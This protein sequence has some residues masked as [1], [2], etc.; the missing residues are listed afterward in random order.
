M[1][2]RDVR[3]RLEEPPAVITVLDVDAAVVDD[4]ALWASPRLRGV[5][6]H[7]RTI[8]SP[9]EGFPRETMLEHWNRSYDSLV[10]KADA[11]VA[12]A[13]SSSPQVLAFHPSYYSARRSE[14]YSTLA[15]PIA[16]K[17]DFK[18]D[19]VVLLIDDIY[20]VQ[21]R[22]GSS[23]DIYDLQK[24]LD[25]HLLSQKLDNFRL[26]FGKGTPEEEATW[27]R[28]RA[29]NLNATLADIAVWRRF[30]MVQAELLAQAHE[31]RVTVLGVKHPFRSLQQLLSD[32]LGTTTT[33]LS[34]PI[35]RPRRAV[36]SGTV[37]GWP[38]VVVS[39]NRL[40]DR[41][42]AEN[43]ELVM[44]TSIDEFRVVPAK[45]TPFEREYRLGPRWPDLS[46]TGAIL[47]NKEPANLALT[48]SGQ[49]VEALGTYA[50]ALE[51]MIIGE[52][53]F[54]DHYLV[55]NTDSF[56]VYR[57]LFGVEG[58]ISSSE[59]GGSFSGGV[60]AEIDHWVDSWD[61]E[62]RKR[63]RRA[64]F[65][66]CYSDV[67]EIVW[68][69]AGL[70]P[71]D[72]EA[73]ALNAH[74]LEQSLRH[75]LR[76]QFGLKHADVEAVLSG[77]ELRDD[78]LDSAIVDAS[79]DPSAILSQA[80]E[81][82]G[83]NYFVQYLTGGIERAEVLESGDVAIYLTEN[84]ELTDEELHACAEYL[85]GESTWQDLLSD[86]SAVLLRGL[87]TGSMGEWVRAM[88]PTLS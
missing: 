24:R 57:P 79:H 42:A 44:P 41:L 27:W 54:R 85:R 29:E 11:L 78:M 25:R 28:L 68:L 87:G 26:D 56:F 16:R 34:H 45:S 43:V 18:F 10:G 48:P 82:A 81:D 83:R 52:V 20:D 3:N 88:L 74:G 22:L 5:P 86:P 75:Y 19:H 14:L 84:E 12:K 35:S 37:T 4:D 77:G 53:P 76:D 63:P 46:P 80:L 39:S 33:Y 59:R 72:Q 51:K 69:W 36:G 60:Q 73:R 1:G 65:V 32:P 61:T 13:D 30:D 62:I 66:H 8:R 9:I 58:A 71:S 21:R 55:S 49:G 15:R 64:L 7:L 40:G 2:L 50:R 38:D 47:E 70:A 6:R 31:C 67:Q 17:D 23:R